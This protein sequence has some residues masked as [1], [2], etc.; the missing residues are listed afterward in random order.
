MKIA[1]LGDGAWGTTLAILLKNKGYDVS[2][3]SVFED[4]IEAIIKHRENKRFLPGV[5]IP[6]R[7]Y[8]TTDLKRAVDNV[9]LIVLAVPS[10]FLR[11]VLMKNVDV[12]KKKKYKFVSVIKGIEQD[13]L[14]T[15]SCVIR[16]VIGNV[17]MAVLSGPSIAPEV[18]RGIPTAVVAASKDTEFRKKVRDVFMTQ[19]FRVY[20][21]K[22]VIGVEFAGALKNIIAIAAGISDGLGFGANTKAAIITRGLAEMTRLGV[23]M[24]GKLETFTGLSG[25][26]DLITTCIS[27]EGRNHRF[28][29]EIGKGK[30]PQDI[31]KKTVS[32]IEGVWTSKA[33]VNLGREYKIDLPIITQVYSVIF[34]NKSSYEAVD[35]L[36]TREPREE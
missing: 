13:N 2:L 29:Q 25:M 31:L 18:A 27:T 1:I 22:D 11:P 16:D 35:E 23:I 14:K 4:N 19:H 17:K 30:N 20:T 9:D 28:G 32:E 15:M 5:K 10:R 36:M 6:P 7:I 21:N 3:W 34:H 26:G 24:G 8:F 33:A 12:L